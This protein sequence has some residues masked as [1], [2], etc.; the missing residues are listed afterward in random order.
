M[1]KKLFSATFNNLLFASTLICLVLLSSM[2]VRADEANPNQDEQNKQTQTGSAPKSNSTTETKPTMQETLTWLKGKFE[3]VLPLQ[4]NEAAAQKVD[5]DWSDDL[6]IL[7][8]RMQ[9]FSDTGRTRPLHYHEVYDV[10]LS[11]LSVDDMLKDKAEEKN[12]V[13]LTPL[14][15]RKI[16]D[17]D[18]DKNWTRDDWNERFVFDTETMATRVTNAFTHAAGLAKAKRAQSGDKPDN[19]PF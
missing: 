17:R 14:R 12:G 1:R 3:T 16:D 9:Y 11:D 8:I 7:T 15:W 18:A 10:R 13:Y 6:D 2:I 19:E 5:V 4:N